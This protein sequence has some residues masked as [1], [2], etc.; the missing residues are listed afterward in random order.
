MAGKY[1]MSSFSFDLRACGNTKLVQK[2]ALSVC[3]NNNLSEYGGGFTCLKELLSNADDA[4]ASTFVVLF[5]RT[6]HRTDTLLSTGLSSQQGPSLLVANDAEF[7]PKDFINFTSKI[8][9][10]SKADDPL[11][12]GRFGKGSLTVWSVGDVLQLVSGSRYLVLDPETAHLNNGTGTWSC[13]LVDKQAQDFVDL[14]SEFPDQMRP[15]QA[16]TR[17][18]GI[19][20]LQAHTHFHGTIFRVAVRS[21]AAAQ[22]SQLSRDFVGV[23]GTS[24]SLQDFM[25]AVPELMLFTRNIKHLKAFVREAEQSQPTLLHQCDATVASSSSPSS[26]IQREQL[27][28]TVT[29]GSSVP[30]TFQVWEKA[31]NASSA[32]QADGVAVLSSLRGLDAPP[33]DWPNVPG[34]LYAGMPLPFGNTRLPLH[35]N[36]AFE[37]SADRRQICGDPEQVS[38]TVC[39]L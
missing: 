13:E 32:G 11:T 2:E 25:Q 37:V 17:C 5:D 24:T 22:A 1:P 4:G 26:G 12:I 23:E 3:I 31:V 34:R 33:Q 6:Q 36:G 29:H 19:R 27:T 16:F 15:L 28:L 21:E 7:S 9:D 38:Y 20:Q 39:T 18:S 8:G 14:F 30:S 10:S 35:I